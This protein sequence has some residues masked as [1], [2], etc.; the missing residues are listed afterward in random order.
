[1][2]LFA[3]PFQLVFPMKLDCGHKTPSEPHVRKK[4]TRTGFVR[5]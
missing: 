4:K 5:V 2:A 3:H 1:L